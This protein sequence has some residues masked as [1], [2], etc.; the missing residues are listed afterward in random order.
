[1]TLESLVPYGLTAAGLLVPVAVSYGVLKTKIASLETD[2][3]NKRG[4]CLALIGE[5]IDNLKDQLTATEKTR[6]KNMDRHEIRLEEMR[7]DIIDLM[8]IV[9]KNG[10]KNDS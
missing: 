2:C 4:Q 8:V 3:T 10:G 1:M 6:S 9:K 5:K 7:K